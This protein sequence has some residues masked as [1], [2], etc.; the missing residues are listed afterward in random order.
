MSLYPSTENTLY[1]LLGVMSV[2]L[3]PVSRAALNQFS[4]VDFSPL[5]VTYATSW[6]DLYKANF[7]CNA[8]QYNFCDVN[9]T[10]RNLLNPLKMEYSVKLDI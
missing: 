1:V 4:L 9:L 6:P 10:K 7:T 2:Q 8:I 3:D 5:N